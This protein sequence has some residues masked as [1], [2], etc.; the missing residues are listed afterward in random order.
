[1][2]ELLR[3]TMN[4]DQ[5]VDALREWAQ[6]R[7]GITEPSASAVRITGVAESDLR[8]EVIFTKKRIRAKVS[9][10]KEQPA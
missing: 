2:K 1:M 10:S 4:E 9:T 3:I 7:C 6:K 8:V 5:I